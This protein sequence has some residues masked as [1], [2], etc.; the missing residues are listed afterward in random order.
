M[1]FDI[2]DICVVGGPM[3]GK[4]CGLRS[5]NSESMEMG[6]LKPVTNLF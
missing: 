3:T 5:T 4:A 1:G 6:Q 2:A